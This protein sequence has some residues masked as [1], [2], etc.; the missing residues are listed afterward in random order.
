MILEQD[1]GFFKPLKAG[2]KRYASLEILNP[3]Y[4][5]Q[6]SQCTNCG[7]WHRELMQF[8]RFEL[9]VKEALVIEDCF[10]LL[11]FT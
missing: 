8:N 1:E 9:D 10:T 7:N 2:Q 6:D 11:F 3:C 5:S 4:D